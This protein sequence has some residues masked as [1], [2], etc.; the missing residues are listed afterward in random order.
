VP[1]Y[2]IISP[3][4]NEAKHL[5]GTIASLVAQT[6][7]PAQWIIVDDGSTDGSLPILEKASAEYPWITLV[8]RADRGCRKPGTG[9]IEA[10]YDGYPSIKSNWNFIVKLD[11][12]VSFD[13][14]YFERC[15]KK[16]NSDPKLGIGGG[17]VC[18]LKNGSI[19]RESDVDP[20]FHVRGATKIYRKEC[21]NAIGELIRAPGW[22]TLDE[23]KA[24]M[25]G[26]KTQTFSDIQLLHHKPAGS[27]DGSW[28]N[29]VKNGLANYIVGYHPL[30]MLL[31]AGN[32]AF[33]KPYAL[34]AVGLLTGF[35]S[36]YL[37]RVPQISDKRLIQ[38][39]RHQQLKR[40]TF[41]QSL[42]K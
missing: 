19:V 2:V 12:D 28:T 20:E 32:R 3:V 26:W 30:F 17:T 27:A 31:N 1:S 29:W 18:N 23:F 8:K 4:R 25:L 22:D 14:D 33:H 38:Y 42:W 40:L 41:Q 37:K 16:F 36:G 11:G 35:F 7:N 5:P 21:W 15:F 10:F 39:L 34:G 13:P 24:N 9:V 6:I